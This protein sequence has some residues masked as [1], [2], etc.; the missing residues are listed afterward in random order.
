MEKLDLMEQLMDVH[1]EN[2]TTNGGNVAQEQVVVMVGGLMKFISYSTDI[3]YYDDNTGQ[4][5]VTEDWEY[6]NTTMKYFKQFIEDY[7]EHD[8]ISAKD[9]REQLKNNDKIEL[10]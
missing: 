3:A 7:T 5:E 6:S 2:L 10:I 4:L 1:V 8:Y 9:F